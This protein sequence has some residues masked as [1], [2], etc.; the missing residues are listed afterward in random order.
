[1]LPMNDLTHMDKDHLYTAAF[2]NGGV[3]VCLLYA[4]QQEL[5]K[6]HSNEDE[7]CFPAHPLPCSK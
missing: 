1:M 7:L 4:G 2:L 6:Q 3:L 5:D